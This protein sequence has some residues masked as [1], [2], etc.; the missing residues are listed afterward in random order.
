MTEIHANTEN[1]KETEIHPGSCESISPI[2]NPLRFLF[3]NNWF[4]I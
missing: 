2:R 1:M 3:N 4:R